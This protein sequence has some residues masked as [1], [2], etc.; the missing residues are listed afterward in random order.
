MKTG[1]FITHI[2]NEGC[3]VLTDDNDVAKNFNKTDRELAS[4]PYRK[5]RK[6]QFNSCYLTHAHAHKVYRITKTL[7]NNKSPEYDN[8]KAE[9]IV[10]CLVDC[11]TSHYLGKRK[12]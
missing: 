10:Y 7:N 2:R 11:G 8:I 1:D 6:K 4:K 3:E 12:H 9:I 5:Q